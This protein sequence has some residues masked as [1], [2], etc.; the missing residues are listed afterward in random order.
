MTDSCTVLLP[1]PHRPP[2]SC[3]S[4]PARSRVRKWKSALSCG[5]GFRLWT[6][7]QILQPTQPA[8]SLILTVSKPQRAAERWLDGYRRVLS[9]AAQGKIHKPTPPERLGARVSPTGR[10]RSGTVI[11]SIR[12]GLLSVSLALY[13]LYSLWANVLRAN[14]DIINPFLVT[15][16]DKQGRIICALVFTALWPVLCH[17]LISGH[18]LFSSG[19]FGCHKA[20]IVYL[21]TAVPTLDWRSCVHSFEAGPPLVP[22]TVGKFTN[23]L[24]NNTHLLNKHG[25][26]ASAIKS[27]FSQ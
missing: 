1:R 21:C 17:I 11:S 12:G 5:L 14:Y 19:L 25:T 7:F 20:E 22:E 4:L 15:F 16:T 26:S 13:T 2:P 6:A 3:L 24:H 18:A 27:L 8:F 10:L 9:T 23:I